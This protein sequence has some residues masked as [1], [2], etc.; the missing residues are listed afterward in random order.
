M[1]DTLRSTCTS[2]TWD[3]NGR[4]QY[5]MCV[6][7]NI[8]VLNHQKALEYDLCS[9]LHILVEHERQSLFKI[10]NTCVCVTC[11]M[12]RKKEKFRDDDCGEF[13]GVRECVCV[14]VCAREA[15]KIMFYD[16]LFCNRFCLLN[17]LFACS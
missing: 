12:W 10:P 14:C 15:L 6:Y 4:L 13:V 7:G 5:S 17:G 11:F 1:C 8:K 3:R 2:G 16:K 9:L